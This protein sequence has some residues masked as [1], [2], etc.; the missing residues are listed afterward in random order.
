MEAALGRLG[1][2]ID[3]RNLNE[4]VPPTKDLQD[5]LLAIKDQLKVFIEEAGNRKSAAENVP[6]GQSGGDV[7]ARR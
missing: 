4:K 6:G 3:S 1:E 2:F 7:D 5:R